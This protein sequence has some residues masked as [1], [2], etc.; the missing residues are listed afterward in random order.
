MTSN[1]WIFWAAL[2]AVFAALT[3]IFAKVGIQNVDSDIATFIR[4]AFVFLLLALFVYFQGKFST[5]LA[6]TKN[7]WVFLG[8]SGLATCASW[9]CFYR[10]LQIGDASKVIVIDK[11]SIVLVAIF[12]VIFLGEKT[13]LKD[14]IGITLVTAGLILI[15]L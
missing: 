9:I 5:S 10:A 1:S 7:T 2:S 15:A 8:L 3:T 14:W 4:T 12:A 6:I 11:F 13:L